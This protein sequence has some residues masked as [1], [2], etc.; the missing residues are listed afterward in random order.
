MRL[1]VLGS[2]GS[3]AGPESAASGYLLTLPGEQPVVLDF[4]PGVL[5]ALQHHTDPNGVAVML[6]HLHADHCLDLPGML[7]WR[8]YHPEPARGRAPLF[9]PGGT[10]IRI[11][12]ASSE[13]AGAVDDISDTFDVRTWVDDEAVI[14]GG[15][16]VLPRRVLH[17]PETYGLR[18]TGP[19]GEVLAF[20]GDSAVCDTLVTLAADADV[21]LCEA[22]WT[23]A[24]NERPPDLHLSGTE[25]GDIA[26]RANVKS[27]LLTHIP[28]WTSVED[29]LCEARAVYRGPVGVARPGQVVDVG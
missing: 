16:T 12:S 28:P 6:S 18:I 25:A 19:R 5:G 2:S 15:M 27:L 13:F 14:I 8:R 20:S 24:P 23:H 9:G 3:V 21:F 1:T 29:V 26:R 22:S 4:G 11:G 17:P 7:V 10:A